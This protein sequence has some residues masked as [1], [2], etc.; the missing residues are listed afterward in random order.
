[1]GNFRYLSMWEEMLRLSIPAR[2]KVTR[3]K[4]GHRHASSVNNMYRFERRCFRN[5]GEVK[6]GPGS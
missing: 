5:D 1:M 3:K 6:L 4:V 2:A